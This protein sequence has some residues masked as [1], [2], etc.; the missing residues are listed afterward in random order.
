MSSSARDYGFIPFTEDE[1]ASSLPEIFERRTQNFAD[2]IAIYTS[3]GSTTYRSLKTAADRIARA[4]WE[5]L[6]DGNEPVV[7]LLSDIREAIAAIFG[8]LKAGKIYLPLDVTL[9]HSRL[10]Y[11]LENSRARLLLADTRTLNL[12]ELLLRDRTSQ[13]IV[14]VDHLENED[15]P[16]KL[17]VTL[18]PDR[19]AALLYTSGSTAQPKGVVHNHRNL[20]HLAMLY[21]NSQRITKEDRI[22][23]FRT[24]TVI[25]GTTHTVGA[26]LNGASLFPHDLKQHGIFNLLDW[27]RAHRITLCSLGPK[28]I[29]TLDGIV[30][31]L[32]PLPALRRIALSGEPVY[33]T[34]VE[35][36]RRL[37]SSACVLV[38]SLGA[39]EAPF[40]VQYRIDQQTKISGD[41]VPVGYPM[42]HVRV[43][44]RDDQGEAVNDG[45]PGEIVLHSRYLA[46]GYWNDPQLTE[47]RFL[48]SHDSPEE[49]LY[50]TGDVGR[51]LPDGTL[52]HL[53]R[54][55]DIVKIRG[56]R[57]SPM[58]IEAALMEHPRVKEVAVIA[59]GEENADKFLTAYIVP[60]DGDRPGTSE[61]MIFLQNRLPDFMVPAQFVFMTEFPQINNK[62][63]RQALPRIARAERDP[64]QSYAAPRS[65]LEA[66]ICEIWEEVLEVAPIGINE[67]FVYL[68]G[69]SLKAT[70]IIA[71]LQQRFG[72]SVAIG[73]LFD[74]G[75]IAGLAQFIIQTSPA[76]G[77]DSTSQGRIQDD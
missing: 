28:L 77:I 55:D 1:T 58:E 29:R 34:D 39:T 24:L 8:I 16:A 76:H 54:K 15:P 60:S 50:L 14:D 47:A 56:Y 6:G 33:K 49:R 38:N 11:F 42:A 26:L 65:D 51:L 4:V 13:K 31:N 22:A 20:L 57:V 36:C 74:A 17:P 63:D 35:I 9:P 10:R 32:D 12:A 40:A 27:L 19:L 23:L 25:G 2:R 67:P 66:A 21:T 75:T 70:K 59:S 44:L 30:G 37:F 69:D 48:P 68:G 45:V 52:L 71:R 41:L 18:T 7:I 43:S 61:L 72:L 3:D 64:D 53:G 62:I 73:A 5:Q 46:M